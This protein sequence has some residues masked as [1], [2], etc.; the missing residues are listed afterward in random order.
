MRHKVIEKVFAIIY[1]GKQIVGFN[2]KGLDSTL[3]LNYQQISANTK[4]PVNEI[5]I[6]CGSR[7]RVTYYKKNEKMF[8]GRICDKDNLIIKEYFIE[9]IGDLEYMRSKNEELILPF[10]TIKKVFQYN[11][12]DKDMV[13]FETDSR[14]VFLTLNQIT[15]LT[16]LEKEEL[17]ILKGS[18]ILPIYYKQGETLRLGGICKKSDVLLK[19]YTLRFKDK[20]EYMHK[21]YEPEPPRYTTKRYS[22]DDIDYT[23][24]PYMQGDPRYDISENPWIDVFGEGEEAE[25]AYWNTQ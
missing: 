9:T 13:G 20:A 18:Y 7:L 11:K 17:H 25:A 8:D 5:E 21:N 19:S 23:N 2:V 16:K 1:K 12:N 15:A 10:L 22:T 3:F 14:T 4:V 24:E 6:L